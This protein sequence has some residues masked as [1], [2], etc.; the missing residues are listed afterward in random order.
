MIAWATE[1]CFGPRH[2]DDGRV[3][4][5]EKPRTLF[6]SGI[7]ASEGERA[8]LIPIVENPGEPL[9]T[10]IFSSATHKSSPSRLQGLAGSSRMTIM[11]PGVPEYRFRISFFDTHA[12]HTKHSYSVPEIS[13]GGR[14]EDD[15]SETVSSFV[16]ES[17]SMFSG[18]CAG[19]G[20]VGV[21]RSRR[22]QHDSWYHSLTQL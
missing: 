1:L 8:R 22:L 6:A 5:C 13:G 16:S 7:L 11:A 20:S 17:G 12:P 9:F 21:S 14:S 10:S 3:D 18:C 4:A 2:K 19:D 15:A